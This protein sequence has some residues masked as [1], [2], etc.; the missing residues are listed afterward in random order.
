MPT[1][2]VVKKEKTVRWPVEIYEAAN[3]GKFDKF[4]VFVKFIDKGDEF[5]ESLLEK[6]REKQREAKENEEEIVT[7]KEVMID[8]L[9]EV[10]VGWD[11]GA[12]LNEDDSPMVFNSGNKEAIIGYAAARTAMFKEYLNMVGGGAHLRKN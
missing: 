8:T 10:L 2:F 12:F 7:L 6:I 3:N 5:N 11:D 9:D 4:K 1:G